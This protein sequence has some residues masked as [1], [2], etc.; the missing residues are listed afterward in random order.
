[1]RKVLSLVVG[2][3]LLSAA[4][5][6]AQDTV[7]PGSIGFPGSIWV[8]A[9]TVGPAEP[10]NTFGQ[11]AIEQGITVWR[12]G[13]WFLTPFVGISAITD[14]HGYDWNNKRP[15]T[16]GVKLQRRIGNGVVSAGGGVMF[17]RNPASGRTRHPSAFVNYWAGWQ[18]DASAQG[19][20]WPKGLPGSINASTALLTGRDPHNWMT[21]VTV[22]QGVVVHRWRGLTTVPYA[23]LG[24]SFDT[25]DRTWQN[26]VTSEAGLKLA[27][28]VTGGIV[29]AG[30]AQ[31]HQY[32]RLTG[33]RSM[34]PALF[35]NFWMGWNPNT[36][37]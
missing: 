6:A 33:R 10:E 35:A 31:R 32:E 13:S 18:G 12:D 17:E 22:Q 1:M 7:A 28:A 23:S 30:I 4:V 16:I 14:S 29:E 11:T 2:S 19:S 26:R 27:R 8:T 25:K 24:V 21:Y 36:V 15:A 9:G 3:V 20:G 34:G 37:R 5:A